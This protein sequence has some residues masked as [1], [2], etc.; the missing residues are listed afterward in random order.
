MCTAPDCCILRSRTRGGGENDGAPRIYRGSMRREEGQMM[1]WCARKCGACSAL[2]SFSPDTTLVASCCLRRAAGGCGAESRGCVRQAHGK[3]VKSAPGEPHGYSSR[4]TTVPQGPK[5][6]LV[7]RWAV[8]PAGCR[9]CRLP[10]AGVSHDR[11]PRPCRLP[12]RL[13]DV[14]LPHR[15]PAALL[16]S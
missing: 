15:P 9:L 1:R 11:T 5:G 6:V 10:A 7:R 13:S 14:H 8:A 16:T 4:T 12:R 2:N 3:M